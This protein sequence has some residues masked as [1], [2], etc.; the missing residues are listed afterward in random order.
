MP[1]KLYEIPESIKKSIDSETYKKW[2]QRKAQTHVRRDRRRGRK[3][4]TIT[5]YKKAI[6]E[7]VIDCRGRDY[8]T[9]EKLRWDLI[10]RYD[11]ENSSK[12]KRQYKKQFEYL[13]SIDHINDVTGPIKFKICSWKVN[14]AKNDLSFQEFVKLCKK[15]IRYNKRTR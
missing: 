14:S 12:G 11:N 2:L 7:A 4:A 3:K 10:G 1:I 5:E 15:V 8:Y 9:G 13:P 6:H